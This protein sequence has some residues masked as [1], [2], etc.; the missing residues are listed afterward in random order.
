MLV[1]PFAHD[2]FDNADR[3]RRLGVGR[4]ISRGKYNAR[5]AEQALDTLLHDSSY[6]Q[7]ASIAGTRI[8]EENGSATAA[9]TIHN[10]LHGGR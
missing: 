1:V 7:A 5:A 3:V 9:R 4:W 2:Q 10:Y 6:A 8:R